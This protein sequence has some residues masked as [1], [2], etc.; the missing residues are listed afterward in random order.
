MFT[1]TEDRLTSYIILF[2]FL[3]GLTS[4]VASYH[5]VIRKTTWTCVCVCLTV[6]DN[7]CTVLCLHGGCNYTLIILTLSKQLWCS[8]TS[9]VM[10]VLFLQHPRPVYWFPTYHCCCL[11]V[12]IFNIVPSLPSTPMM[13]LGPLAG[14]VCS[15]FASVVEL[16]ESSHKKWWEV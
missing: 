16:G 1:E 14:W 5:C 8:L 9:V 15:Y 4:N 3:P 12:F 2:L 13:H 10:M 11:L 6:T 7:M